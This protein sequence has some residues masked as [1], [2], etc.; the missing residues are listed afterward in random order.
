[1]RAAHAVYDQSVANYRET[2]ITACQQV[3]DELLALHVLQ[4]EADSAATA[5][6]DARQAFE[7]SLAEYKAG[8]VAYTSVVTAEQAYIADE[9]TALTIQQNRLVAG[10]SLI[11]VLG[12]GW[13]ASQLKR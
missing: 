7:V 6:A 3:E 5:V 10:V 9:Q 1:M 12:G 11:E 8:T 13:D 2:V 4:D